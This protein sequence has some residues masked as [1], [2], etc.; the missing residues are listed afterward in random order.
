MK[1]ITK[2]NIFLFGTIGI[3]VIAILIVSIAI[4][5]FIKSNTF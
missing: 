4:L 3:I 1:Q 2:E 5:I